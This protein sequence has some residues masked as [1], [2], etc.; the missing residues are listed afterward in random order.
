[1]INITYNECIYSHLYSASTCPHEIGNEHSHQGF[2]HKKLLEG[3]RHLSMY[4][5]RPEHLR[6]LNTRLVLIKANG[7]SLLHVVN[8]ST[9]IRS[10]E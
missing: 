10:S 2:I 6:R 5:V 1:M 9:A 8:V 7:E 4:T 3:R